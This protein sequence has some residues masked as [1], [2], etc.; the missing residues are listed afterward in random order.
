[1]EILAESSEEGRDPGL[2]WV[3]GHVVRFRLDADRGDP[4]VPHM[5]WNQVLA[6]KTNPLIF[7]HEDVR[8]Y[9]AHSFH[10]EANAPED[11][12]GWTTWGYPFASAV[13]RGNVMG[14]QFHP[15]K[16]HRFGL[17]LL[18]RFVDL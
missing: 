15:E 11:V 9:F 5:G 3:P 14:V 2:G 7:E 17:E 18:R 8:F 6:A 12:V 10:F 13:Q 16:S 4:P 1:M